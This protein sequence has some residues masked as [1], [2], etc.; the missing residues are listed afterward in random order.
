MDDGVEL[1]LDDLFLRDAKIPFHYNIK[2]KELKTRSTEELF[3]HLKEIF[4]K[5]LL[6]VTSN[7]LKLENPENVSAVDI[8]RMSEKDFKNVRDRFLSL[9][10][11]VKHKIYDESDKD[12]YLRSVCYSAEKIKDLKLEVTLDWNTQYINKVAFK[13]G[14]KDIVPKIMEAIEK[15][16][17]SNYFL[18][19]AKPKELKDYII[20][21]TLK[22]EPNKLHVINFDA[23][24][25]T[26]HHYNHALCTPE[27][28]HIR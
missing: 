6:L 23:A 27:T 3:N 19:L 12:Y 7:K 2:F 26:D 16:P 21:Y 22:D 28:R 18:A 5:G 24:K 9:G 11:D 20:K 14:N 25:I 13:A 8:G 4:A 15:T 10:I 1:S 17:E